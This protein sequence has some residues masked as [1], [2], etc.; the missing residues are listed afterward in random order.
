[1]SFLRK[2]G[3][4]LGAGAAAAGGFFAG[5][6]FQ[7]AIEPPPVALGESPQAGPEPAVEA[8]P[9]STPPPWIDRLLWRVAFV[10]ITVWVAIWAF[11]QLSDFLFSLFIA[12]FLSL[13]LEPAV[14]WLHSKGWRRG[15]ATFAVMGAVALL[16]LI[17]L[18]VLIPSIIKQTAELIKNLPSWIQDTSTWLN[19]T[20]KLDL[21]A[22]A[23]KEEL[24]KLD[25]TVAS[26]ASDVAGW[27]LGAGAKLVGVI[28]RLMTI[29]LFTFYFVADGPRFRRT[30]CSILPRRRQEEVLNAWEVAIDKTGGYLYSR[31]LLATVSAGTSWIVMWLLG[32]P[33]ALPLAI[34]VGI[35][36]QFIP[37]VGTYIAMALPLVVSVF[38]DPID[39]LWLLIWFT[40]YQQ[41][42]NYW[43]SPH[44]TAKTME[45]H[46]AIAFGSAIAGGT[47]FGPIG[48]FLALPFVATIQS[49]VLV[50]VVKR[51]EVIDSQ[52]TVDAAP[53]P[54]HPPVE[55]VAIVDDV[56]ARTRKLF[57][58]K[59]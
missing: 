23:L 49:G 42:E 1:M 17:M 32:V 21:S 39:A 58:R 30:V 50:Y 46:P 52:L 35:I 11:T 31:L 45:L 38:V 2:V 15:L 5:R 41:I 28:F 33:F 8:E 7:E 53:E 19:D 22:D 57:R 9:G 6:A 26:T 13:A 29:G 18:A 14:V 24:S 54:R 25:A 47:L 48:A 43:L 3:A 16:G 10:A 44:I 51:H 56:K 36:S 20:F 12:F 34:W 40:A 4:G 55:E 27:I 59:G 37:T